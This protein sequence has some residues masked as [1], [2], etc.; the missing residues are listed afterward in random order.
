MN[1]IARL[2]KAFVALT[3]TA[4]IGAGVPWALLTWIGSPVPKHAPTLATVHAWMSTRL[5]IHVFI[6]I[7]VYLLWACWAVFVTQSLC[8]S[9]ASSP[10]LFGSSVTANRCTPHR[11]LA[12]AGRWHAA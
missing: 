1:L 11:P 6:A 9:Q 5:D 4:G 3:V 10:T 2:V 12:L 8:R 7:A